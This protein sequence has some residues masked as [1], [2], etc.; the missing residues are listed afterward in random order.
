M[1]ESYRRGFRQGVSAIVRGLLLIEADELDAGALVGSLSRFER[2][3]EAWLEDD[4]TTSP[5]TW[6]PSTAEL[7]VEGAGEDA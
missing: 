5:P 7:G 4:A 6:E 1:D 2:E 3:V